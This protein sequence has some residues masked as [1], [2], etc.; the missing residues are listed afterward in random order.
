MNQLLQTFKKNN[1]A[2]PIWLMRQ[3][4]RYLPEYQ[5]IRKTVSGFLD[6]CYDVNKA[7]EVTLQPI[8]RYNFDAAIIFSDILVLPD[9]L[10]WDVKFEENIG[11]ILRKFQSKDDF[12]YLKGNYSGKLNV[13][14]DIINKIKANLPVDTALIGFAGSPWTVMTYMLEGRGKQNFETSKKFIYE[15]NNL[16]QELLDF[17]TEKTIIHLIG[18]V[19]AG[20]DLIQLFDS[21]AGILGELEYD[22]FVIQPTKKIVVA[23]KEQFPYLPII[24]FP[25]ISG[26]LY[27]KYISNTG[28]DVIGVDQFVPIDT[29]KLWS[30]KVVVQGNLDPFILLTNKEIIAKKVDKIIYNFKERNFIFNLGH[31]VLPNTPVENVEF[32]VNYVRKFKY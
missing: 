12:K 4:G 31:G 32:L 7:V 8:R 24:G 20:A 5:K 13:V 11:P 16:A 25:R 28:V 9:A 22:Q 3:A 6:L 15:N 26:L 30:K 10:G 21:W 14:Y 1:T 18:Q 23:L 2:I 29:M 19:K 27:E 17:I